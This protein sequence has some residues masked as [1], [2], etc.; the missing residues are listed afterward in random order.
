MKNLTSS[1]SVSGHK[2][3][4]VVHI[5]PQYVAVYFDHALQ[6]NKLLM[7]EN[8]AA[9]PGFTISRVENERCGGFTN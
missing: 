2:Q 5:R 3:R 1:R 6:V 7:L 9:G 8:K 4:F